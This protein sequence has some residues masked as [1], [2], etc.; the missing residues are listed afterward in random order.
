[1]KRRMN[2]QAVPLLSV[3]A[4]F[5]F[6]IMMFNLPLPGGTTGHAVGVGIAAI[7]LGPWGS[8]LA[9]SV[10]LVI[11][12]IFFG[13]GGITAIGAN[14]FNMAIVGSLVAYAVYRLVAGRAPIESTRR[15]VAAAIAGY[16]AI[17]ASALLAAIEF[18]IQPMLFHDA[19][20][21]PLYAPYPLHIAIPAMMIGHLTIAGLAEMIVS[22]GVVAYLQRAEPA[23]LKSTAP[24]ASVTGESFGWRGLRPLWIALAVLLILTPLGILAAGAAWGEWMPEDFSTPQARRQIAAASGHQA[25]PL[26]APSGLQKLSNIWTAPMPRYAPPI[27]KS[28][29]LGYLLSA[30]VGAG[31]IVLFFLGGTW[32]FTRL[33]S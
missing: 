14:C 11:Q 25:P 27:L 6:V 10:A 19:S 20:G 33:R 31:L 8:I 22:A 2:T 28:P 12:A 30:M 24:G 7:V 4:A 17:N 26:Q 9:I 23:L 13:D 32:I 29:Q 21:T 16:A 15:V 18:G 1:M 5:S 3:F